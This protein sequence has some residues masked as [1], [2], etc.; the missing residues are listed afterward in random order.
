MDVVIDK[1]KTVDDIV[2]SKLKYSI[3]EIVLICGCLFSAILMYIRVFYGTE[4]TDEA[5]YVS[6][7]LGMLHGNI[8]YVH[9][10]FS[11]GTG[12][13]FLLIPQLFLYEIFVPNLEGVLLFT[14]LSYVSFRFFILFYSFYVLKKTIKKPHALLITGVMIPVYGSLIQ[15]YS[16]NTIPMMLSFF[17]GLL[18][19]DC[20]ENIGKYRSSKLFIAGFL[21]GISIF[22]HPGYGI[23]LIVFWILLLLRSNKGEKCKNFIIYCI[24][25]V[26][27][28]LAVFIPIMI[29]TGG[30]LLLDGLNGYIHPYPS[31]NMASTTA[32]ERIYVLAGH[33]KRIL[34]IA[35]AVFIFVV[36]LAVRYVR[37]KGKRLKTIEYMQ[38]GIISGIF[39]NILWIGT[40]VSPRDQF[41]FLGLTAS[42]YLLVYVVGC[43]KL[44]NYPLF[45]YLSIYPA[46]FSL[47]EVVIVDSNASI[48]R[49]YF[50]LPVLYGLLLLLLENESELIR[51]ITTVTSIIII[52]IMGI[53]D[54]KYVYRDESI[55]TL[56]YKV[57]EGVYAGIYTTEARAKALPELEKY[58]NT[59][60]KEDEYYAFRDNVPCG[61]LMTHHGR[62]C[63]IATWDCLQYTYGRNSPARLF[64]YYKRKNAIPDKIIYVDYGRD[65]NLSIE[66]NNYRYNDF[67]NEYYT[68]VD[69]VKLN[70]IFNHVMVYE[71]NGQFDSD[72]DYWINT[73]KAHL[74]K[75]EG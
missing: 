32:I 67:V 10:N 14:R 7:A 28:I 35:A 5:F 44:I 45:Y 1:Y 63:D 30:K 46:L 26:F 13:A 61:Y 64:D 4:I 66:D 43:K 6:D 75:S 68:L 59:I 20:V 54:F 57:K 34:L 36:P 3:Y 50:A 29:Q 23:S 49:F 21:T 2:K 37:E 12:S 8:P 41:S 69:N 16:Y 24:G 71:Y 17:V 18:L 70:T 65:D 55:T 39:V 62:M 56:D 33:S 22:A 40:L 15:N 11:Y 60:V 19:Y 31:E 58:L 27:E 53:S 52:L 73:Y 9:N 48:D 51:V 74:K 42:I 38:L 25:G 72:Y 47:A